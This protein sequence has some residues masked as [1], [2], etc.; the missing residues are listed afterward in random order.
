M[1]FAYG[2]AQLFPEILAEMKRP[3]DFIKGMAF[4][5][6]LIFTAYVFHG[7]WVVCFQVRSFPLVRFDLPAYASL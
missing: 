4:A 1:I 5:Q 7:V 2:G 6:L 3:W